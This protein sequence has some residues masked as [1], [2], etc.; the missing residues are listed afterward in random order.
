MN[1]LFI[2]IRVSDINDNDLD[3]KTID[4]F[5]KYD[6]EYE[7]QRIYLTNR[8]LTQKKIDSFY[9]LT[10]GH[11]FLINSVNREDG[12]F[13]GYFLDTE[14]R[15]NSRFIL[16]DKSEINKFYQD[17]IDKG[18]ARKYENAVYDI[19]DNGRYKNRF[20]KSRNK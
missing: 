11:E 17:I 2:M 15:V 16:C 13:D 18:L 6:I 12:S 5:K 9:E 14:K 8:Y 4:I 3:N 10:T 1:N 19:L 7:Y 20:F